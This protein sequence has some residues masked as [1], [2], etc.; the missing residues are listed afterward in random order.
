MKEEEKKMM[1]LLSQ[2]EKIN[3]FSQIDEKQRPG[4]YEVEFDATGLTSGIYFY[5][6]ITGRF[7]QTKMMILNK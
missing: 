6:I 1:Q 3:F 5:Q 2:L 7:C 4:N